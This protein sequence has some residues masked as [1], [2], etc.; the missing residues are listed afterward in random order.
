MSFFVAIT[1]SPAED[2]LCRS[3]ASSTRNVTDP[4]TMGFPSNR[5]AAVHNVLYG[6]DSRWTESV[7]NLR[8][9]NRNTR[10]WHGANGRR[11]KDISP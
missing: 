10:I 3:L 11:P 1:L 4:R 7:R 5:I 8:W 9:G 6:D 2:G